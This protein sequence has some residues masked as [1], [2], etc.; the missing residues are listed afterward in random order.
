MIKMKVTYTFHTDVICWFYFDVVEGSQIHVDIL[1]LD[2]DVCDD[3]YFRVWEYVSDVA[4][5]QDP[6]RDTDYV[7]WE[8]RPATD[9]ELSTL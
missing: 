2:M 3:A 5:A 1:N 9:V 4:D 6:D 8:V 7:N